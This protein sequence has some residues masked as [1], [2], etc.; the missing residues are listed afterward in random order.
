MTNFNEDDE[1]VCI[2]TKNEVFCG[3]VCGNFVF[4]PNWDN[5]KPLTFRKTTYIRMYVPTCE[6]VLAEEFYR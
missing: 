2:N 1:V 3:M 5:A 6:Y 4:S